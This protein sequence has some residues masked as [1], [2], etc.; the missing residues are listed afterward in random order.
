MKTHRTWKDEFFAAALAC[1]AALMLLCVV[2]ISAVAQV[3]E[4]S[5]L[6][7]TVTDATG[8]VMPNVKVTVVDQSTNSV[9]TVLT[10]SSG[11][12]EVPGIKGGTYSVSAEKAGFNKSVVGDV[13]IMSAQQKRVDIQ[14]QVG[15]SASQVTISAA[16]EVIQ[17]EGGSIAAEATAAQYKNMPIPGNAYSY[18]GTV[19]ATL[20]NVGNPKG[21]TSVVYFSGQTGNQVAQGMDGYLEFTTGGQ[22][23]SNME[24]VEELEVLVETNSAEYSRLGAFNLVTKRGSNQY[25]GD[26]S[27]YNRNS[28]LGA[29][30]FFDTRK[31]PVNYNTMTVQGSGPVIRNKTFVYFMYN[32]ERVGAHTEQLS[33][34]PTPL[35]RNG[36]FSQL[37]GGSKPTTLV[38]PLSGQPF[39]G[40]VIPSSR[41]NPLSLKVMNSYIPLPNLGGPNAQA[42]NLSWVFPYITDQYAADVY[43]ARID[44]KITSKNSVFGR[45]GTYFPKYISLG[46]YP[47]L[48]GTQLRPNYSWVITDTHVFSPTLLNEFTYGG[49]KDTSQYGP[50]LKGITPVNGAQVVSAIGLQGVNSENLSGLGFPIMNITGYPALQTKTAGGTSIN[51]DSRGFNDAVTW[52]VGRHTMKFGF[53]YRTA[54]TK[55]STIPAGSFGN[56]TFGGNFSGN[57]FAD[58][59]LGF[60]TTSSRLNPILDRWQHSAEEGTFATDTFRI[61]QRLTLTYGLRWDYFFSGSFE[62]GLQ[63]NWDPPT[64]KVIIPQAALSRI[65]PLY[66]TNIPIVPGQVVPAPS[67]RDFAPR[68]AVAYQLSKK[69]VLR[70]GFGIYSEFAGAFTLST[71]QGAGPFQIA[72][73]YTNSIANGQ[74]LFSFP[75]PFPAAGAAVPSQSVTGYPLEYHPGRFAQYN[76]TLERQI[77][78]VGLRI[79]YIGS[80]GYDLNYTKGINKPQPSLTPFA[81]SRNPYPQF[82]SAS[83]DYSNGRSE[84]N[85]LGVAARR[86]VGGL[87][88]DWSWTWA[89]GLKN[90]LNT[91]NPYAPLVWAKDGVTPHDRVVL[92]T[93]WDIPVGRNRR[94]L[95]QL[96]RGLDHVIGGW[97]LYWIGFFQTGNWFSPSYSGSDRSNT[98]TVGGI[99]NR[100]CDGNLPSSQR[101]V[102]HWFDTSC[103]VP[104]PVGSFGNSGVNILV[105]PGVQSQQLSV[106]KVFNVTERFRLQFSAMS[107]NILNHPN[108]SNPASNVSVATGGVISSVDGFY[109]NDKDGPRTVEFRLHLSF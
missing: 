59:L 11:D 64:G 41:L 88:L 109:S 36:D 1:V 28:Y 2:G 100:I 35:M 102:N 32:G 23:T 40:N 65:S 95:A 14:L 108:F 18:P 12:F 13:F 86:R 87:T 92:N 29:R 80:E 72:Q 105:G 84:Y 101:T 9:R 77:G 81:A 6:R 34:V 20:P 33:T 45:I 51:A 79:S 85:A 49:N 75:N 103:F 82:V 67:K 76:V 69:M 106:T 58:F 5:T 73:T 91:E 8:A 25:H 68:V 63:Y 39:S 16:A 37:L 48:T 53:Q 50:G 62:D 74:P 57:A 96:P 26:L 21:N 99:P 44:Q 55:N 46:N 3:S 19:L 83:F 17:T 43:F 27:Y 4:L 15:A 107:S 30:G 89:N 90:T 93:A 24:A 60:P 104:P 10:D 7:G 54:A 66:P 98:N 42:N 52:T 61:N 31:Q 56:F 47:S 38:D 71:N 94:Y 22:Q 78:S 97:S 70:A